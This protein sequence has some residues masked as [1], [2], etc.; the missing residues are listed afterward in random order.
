MGDWID[1]PVELS[2]P[3]AALDGFSHYQNPIVGEAGIIKLDLS[4]HILDVPRSPDTV[5]KLHILQGRPRG[6]LR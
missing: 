2:E 3:M 5:L 1:P 4:R 6:G